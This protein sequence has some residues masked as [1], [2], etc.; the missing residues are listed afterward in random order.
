MP[1]IDPTVLGT[2]LIKYQLEIYEIYLMSKNDEM[3]EKLLV[4]HQKL[5]AMILEVEKLVK[6][7][8]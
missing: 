6:S 3:S 7:E 5:G 4:L 1:K 8:I 2:I